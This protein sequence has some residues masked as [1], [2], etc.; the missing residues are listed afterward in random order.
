MKDWLKAKKTT[1]GRPMPQRANFAA[2][3]AKL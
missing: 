3:V 1:P 2:W